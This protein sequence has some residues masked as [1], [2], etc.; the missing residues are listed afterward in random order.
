MFLIFLLILI[1]IVVLEVNKEGLCTDNPV[2]FSTTNVSG[3]PV[4]WLG[5]KCRL[6][7]SGDYISHT[8][9]GLECTRGGP[10]SE[11][12]Y[13]YSNSQSDMGT[14]QNSLSKMY[15]SHDGS[16]VLLSPKFDEKNL[17][18]FRSMGSEQMLITRSI[19]FERDFKYLCNEGGKLTIKDNV[20]HALSLIHI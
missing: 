10:E 16:E 8:H 18:S 15:M 7:F 17:F 12:I 14:F 3:D 4:Y 9:K 2:L 6:S 13:V 20:T 19:Y 5:M 1:F 11:W